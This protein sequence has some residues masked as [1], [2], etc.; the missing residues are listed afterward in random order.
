MVEN[1]RVIFIGTPEFAVPPLQALLEHSYEIC[2][3]FTQPDRPSGRGHKLQASPVKILAQ[4]RNIPVFQP[5]KI[6]LEENRPSI[7]SLAPDFVVV[8]AYGQILPGW[9]LQAA[10]IATINIHASLLP[11]YRGAAPI[12]RSI[13]NGDSMTG[14]TTMLMVEK[15]D[16]G[17]VLL[18]REVPISLTITMGELTN[19]L[20]LAGAS[21]LIET[22]AGMRKSA[23][24]PV[25]Q[26][27]TLV[28]WAPRI[29]KESANIPWEKNS[30]SIHNHIR[31]MNPWPGAYA[32]YRGERLI[33][34]RS[35]PENQ[36]EQENTPGAFL[37][38]SGQGI[39]VQ[40]GQ[41]TVLNLLELQAPA[42]KKVAGREFINGIRLRAGEMLFGTAI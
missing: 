3:V 29:S 31:A 8:A 6:R 14:V 2:G 39:R 12:A 27:E 24:T 1:M 5:E 17:P 22:L 21:L 28:S 37:G 38:I 25:G 30:L 11:K 23:I 33:V 35:L 20:S 4:S 36:L 18:Q 32:E 13:L 10:R 34:W 7:E 26:D 19:E 40:C 16:A 15:L 41:G 42:K 9:L